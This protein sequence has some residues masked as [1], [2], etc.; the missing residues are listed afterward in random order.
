VFEE[1]FLMRSKGVSEPTFGE[2]DGCV[3][4]DWTIPVG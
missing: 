2:V 1:S 3:I 4:R